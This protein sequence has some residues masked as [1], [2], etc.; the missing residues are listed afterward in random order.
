MR[1]SRGKEGWRQGWRE[2]WR[3]WKNRCYKC[4]KCYKCNRK[5][6]CTYYTYLT[7]HTYCTYY[8]YYT[9]PTHLTHLSKKGCQPFRISNP[10]FSTS[11]K[12]YNK[13]DFE[14]EYNAEI[15]LLDG[16]S[17]AILRAKPCEPQR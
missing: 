10:Y 5:F 6:Y 2:G 17:I 8:T 4:Y 9:Y 15:T 1:K 16:F 12:S 3:E 14:D 13:R 7:Y 11:Q